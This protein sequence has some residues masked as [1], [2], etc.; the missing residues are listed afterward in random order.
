LVFRRSAVGGRLSRIVIDS[1]EVNFMPRI[2]GAL[3]HGIIDY[4]IVVMLI[5]GPRVAAFRGRQA[6]F[7]YVIAFA[8]LAL[9][10]L[11]RFPLGV[12]KIVAFPLHGGIELLIAILMIA[13]PFI[14]NFSAGVHS[15]NFF[16]AI[17]VLIGVI[18]ALT[19]YRGRG[20]R[21]S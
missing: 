5:I 2:I 19:D 20:P 3:S 10:V 9:T 15:R 16:L 7:A 21:P 4:A 12:L 13:L 6:I 8:F 1:I 17:G 18:G 11:T 14:G